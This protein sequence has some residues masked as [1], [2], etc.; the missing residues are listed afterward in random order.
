MGFSETETASTKP[1]VSLTVLSSTRRFDEETGTRAL[2]M[3]LASEVHHLDRRL[4]R[5]LLPLNLVEDY[6]DSFLLP[7]VCRPDNA[8]DGIEVDPRHNAHTLIHDCVCATCRKG[9]SVW[10]ASG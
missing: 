2:E 8:G 1:W 10:T 9:P 5:S 3:N 6:E 7:R 4:P